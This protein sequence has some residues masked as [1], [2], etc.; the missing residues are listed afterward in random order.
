MEIEDFELEEDE[1]EEENNQL[2]ITIAST[3]A[4]LAGTDTFADVNFIVGEGKEQ[5]SI[6]AHSVILAVNSDVFEAMLYP[7]PFEE[8]DLKDMCRDQLSEELPEVIIKDVNPLAFRTM[9]HCLYSDKSMISSSELVDLI[10]VAKK[11]QLRQLNKLCQ[12]FLRSGINIE[13][14]CTLY[15]KA[16]KVEEV[17]NV[18]YS[19]IEDE[20]KG[21]FKSEG[22]MK[23]NKECIK[24]I[25][26]SDQLNIDE[27]ELFSACMLWCKAECKRRELEETIDNKKY[28]L[29]D[30]LP[31]IRF[32][33]MKLEDI[34]KTINPS[35]ILPKEQVLQLFTYLGTEEKK[36]SE[37]KV[38][39]STQKREA[40]LKWGFHEINKSERI[41]IEKLRVCSNL[42]SSFAYCMGDK[43]MATGK[44]CWQVDR[45]SFEDGTPSFL[46]LGVSSLAK[47]DDASSDIPAT[48]KIW[49]FS[50]DGQKYID[51]KSEESE[52]Q[53]DF[54]T[55]P[56]QLLL[57]CEEGSLDLVNM[58]TSK[59]YSI[60]KM[61][62]KTSVS[63]LTGGGYVPYFNF[64]KSNITIIPLSYKKFNQQI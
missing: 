64:K 54:T 37:L 38:D 47:F 39:F 32:P 56:F 3:L 16:Q 24:Q 53:V 61:P 41:K 58:H 17:K 57:D 11:F 1:Q 49:G 22:F 30:I 4:D 36:R 8:T 9:L 63:S 5:R 14:V 13:N 62:K 35:K 48:H 55:G 27:I 46:F 43:P 26:C 51:G 52:D 12:D 40:V 19:F 23:L 45:Y 42:S 18:A 10:Y 7:F 44:H 2:K 29:S 15:T 60:S 59:T 21:V 6:P 28:I 33:V 31:L 20:A 34:A 50:S 25:L